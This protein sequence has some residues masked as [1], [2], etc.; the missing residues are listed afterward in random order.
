MGL[1]GGDGNVGGGVGGVGVGGVGVGVIGQREQRK[2]FSRPVHF[3]LC[4]TKSQ[5]YKEWF[6]K[7]SVA[8]EKMEDARLESEKEMLD[9]RAAFE[10]SGGVGGDGAG[11]GEGTQ[12]PVDTPKAVRGKGKSVK[13]K[14][15][16]KG[17]VEVAEV[18]EV[19]EVEGV[20]E[21][22]KKS[23]KS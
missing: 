9:M 1:L 10:I 21:G 4:W 22:K 13:S 17:E 16:K 6:L 20:A 8:M 14:K 18:A 7:S 15:G 12:A 23:K 5:W 11:G 19:V 3:Q 2:L